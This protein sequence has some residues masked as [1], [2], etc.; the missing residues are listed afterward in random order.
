MRNVGRCTKDDNKDWT[1]ERLDS[2]RLGCVRVCV[3][4]SHR[5]MTK[6]EWDLWG[7]LENFKKWY[8]KVEL[9]GGMSSRVVSCTHLQYATLF[10]DDTFKTKARQD[11]KMQK[12]FPEQIM[13]IISCLKTKNKTLTR[14]AFPSCFPVATN[15]FVRVWFR[16]PVN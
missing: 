1:K 4:H 2:A 11:E 8:T 5:F 14:F 6:K 7:N 3:G 16:D 15:A 12:I 13:P 9:V 10:N